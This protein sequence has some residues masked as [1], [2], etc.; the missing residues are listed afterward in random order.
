[1]ATDGDTKTESKEKNVTREGGDNVKC[2]LLARLYEQ[3]VKD[4]YGKVTG[5]NKFTQGALVYVDRDTFNAMNEFKA[6]FEEVT[7]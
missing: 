4:Q 3:P 7:D 6:S 1:M 5:F 2:R